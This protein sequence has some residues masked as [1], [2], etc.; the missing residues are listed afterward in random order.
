MLPP[1]PAEAEIVKVATAKVAVT[2]PGPLTVMVVSLLPELATETLPVTVQ[3]ENL[4]P[5]DGSAEIATVLEAL[6][7]SLD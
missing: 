5:V 6:Y 4:Y 2:S 3:V 7:Q 1:E